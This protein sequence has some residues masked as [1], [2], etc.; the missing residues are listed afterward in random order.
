MKQMK[1]FL[2]VS[3]LAIIH[4]L[5]IYA[6]DIVKTEGITSQLHKDNI[7]KIFFSEKDMATS[8]LQPSNF[9][10]TYKLTNKSNLYFIAYMGNSMTNYLHHLAPALSADSLVKIGNYQFTLFVDD[11][12]VYQSN[13]FP[14]APRATIQDTATVINKPFID[15]VKDYGLW[16]ESFWNRFLRYGGDSALTEGKHILKMEI[17]P[18]L[19]TSEV[20]VG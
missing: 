14:G 4:A 13:L 20:K 17:R 5:P 16:S 12:L 9:L 19:K 10:N 1:Q 2:L 8:A 15:Y 7:G 3:Y 18:Y 6:Q 11:K